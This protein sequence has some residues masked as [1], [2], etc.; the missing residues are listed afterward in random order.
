MR[1]SK[2]IAFYDV[3]WVDFGSINVLA[4]DGEFEPSVHFVHVWLLRP[5]ECLVKSADRY[6]HQD[7]FSYG[8]VSEYGILKYQCTWLIVQL[9]LHY[10]DICMAPVTHHKA[11][12]L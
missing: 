2:D 9:V 6:E 5:L 3:Q 8:V 12:T 1:S 4:R 11:I 7:L 10:C